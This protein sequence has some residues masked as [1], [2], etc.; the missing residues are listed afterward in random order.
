VQAGFGHTKEHALLL[1]PGSYPF[2]DQRLP[3]EQMAMTEAPA[4]LEALFRREAKAN[5]I[6]L[7]RDLPVELTLRSDAM[8]DATFLIWW[9][10]DNER[11]HML[12]P[13]EHVR[14]RA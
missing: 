7:I 12:V 8:P 6:E 9:P 5:G 14:G 4:D 3:L 11:I 2:V 13:L 1:P 10:S